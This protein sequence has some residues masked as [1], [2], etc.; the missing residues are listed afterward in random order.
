MPLPECDI[1]R[2]VRLVSTGTLES[3]PVADPW[4][5]RSLTIIGPQ[6]RGFLEAELETCPPVEYQNYADADGSPGAGPAVPASRSHLADRVVD[7]G[8]N[9]TGFIAARVQCAAPARRMLSFDELVPARGSV[10]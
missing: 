3:H 7:F 1:A 5:D 10:A 8:T 4:K 9:R 6:F 2:P